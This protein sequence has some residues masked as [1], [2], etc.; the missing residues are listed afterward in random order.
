MKRAMLAGAVVLSLA[1]AGPATAATPTERRLQRQ[2]TTLQRDVRTLRT[3]VREAREAAVAGIVLGFCVAATTAD[4]F[5]ST[6]TVLDQKAGGQAVGP[7]QAVNDSGAC[8]AIQVPRSQPV[9]PTLGPFQTIL[10]LLA[11]RS[12]F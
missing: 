5:Q 7:Q 6:W 11:F 9:P 8:N 1:L 4:A 3:Q 10:R 12:L 2:I